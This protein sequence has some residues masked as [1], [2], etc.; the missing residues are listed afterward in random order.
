[1]R[2]F[3]H[4][5]LSNQP[6]LLL[7]FPTEYTRGDWSDF[8]RRPDQRSIGSHGRVVDVGPNEEGQ[9]EYGVDGLLALSLL[10]LFRSPTAISSAWDLCTSIMPGR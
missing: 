8:H 10:S 6:L 3:F 4:T 5:Y 1:M 7:F 9:L 2:P